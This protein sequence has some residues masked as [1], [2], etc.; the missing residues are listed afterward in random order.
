METGTLKKRINEYNEAK[1]FFEDT[2]LREALKSY[3]I[4]TEDSSKN[5]I[6]NFLFDLMIELGSLRYA[7]DT[8]HEN[9]DDHPLVQF[10]AEQDSK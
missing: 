7:V 8:L 2:K 9:R 1:N 5:E 3:G 4:T 6:A 10:L